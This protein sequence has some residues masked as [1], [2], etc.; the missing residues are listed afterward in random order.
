MI[1]SLGRGNIAPYYCI[2]GSEEYLRRTAIDNIIGNIKKQSGDQLTVQKMFADEAG[3]DELELALASYSL[4]SEKSVVIIKDARKLKQSCWD[5]IDRFLDAPSDAC[6][7]ILED[8]KFDSRK[9]SIKKIVKQ[10]HMYDFPVLY[11]NER[12]TWIKSYARKKGFGISDEAA[13]Y[14]RDSVEP[15]LTHYM[16]EFEKIS[17]F[18]DENTSITLDDLKT[19]TRSTRAFN[20]FEFV[21]ALFS[22]RKNKSIEYFNDIFIYNESVPGVI[23]MIVRQLVILL[24]IKLLKTGRSPGNEVL[25]KIGITRFHYEKFRQQ[26]DRF[27]IA[28][29][30]DCLK[31]ALEA[32]TNLKTGKQSDK[33]AL[34]LLVIRILGVFRE[35]NAV[36]K[37]YA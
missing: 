23:V 3:P 5:I 17:L 36:R 20:I 10:K 8:E 29:L 18:L 34:T 26:A 32:D 21:E 33:M 37:A 13:Q 24:K 7:L 16:Q 19:V 6:I 11:D 12:L 30:N 28:D 14:L 27:S 25:R 4:F 15:K 31:A 35:S 2:S 9:K 22:G 1:S